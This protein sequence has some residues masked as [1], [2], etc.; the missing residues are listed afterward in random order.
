M[1]AR[2]IGAIAAGNLRRMKLRTTL[3]VAGIV[4]AIA[5]FTSMVSFGTGTQENVERQFNDLGLLSTM[6]VYPRQRSNEPEQEGMPKLDAA[7]LDQFAKIPGVLIVYPYDPFTVGVRCGDSVIETRAQSLALTML[8]TKLFSRIRAGVIF[9]SDTSK[10]AVVSTDFLKK[11]G[12]S[13]PDSA[14]GR[15]L[16][17]SVR[18]STID[19][20]L[21]RVVTDRGRPIWD[22]FRKIRIDSLLHSR[23][24]LLKT[25]RV[26]ANEAVR[27]LV[28]GY[29]NARK[30]ITDTLVICGVIEAERMGRVRV[31][32][33]LL[34]LATGQRFTTSGM[35]SNP[36]DLFAAMSSGTLF[37]GGGDRQEKYFTQATLQLDPR[38]PWAPIKDSIEARGYRTFSFAQE[39]TQIQKAFIYLDM[40]LGAVGLLALLTASLGIVNTMAMSL[41]ERRREIGIFKSLGAD[42]GEI[43]ILFLVESGMV[44]LIGSAAG[45]L[46][47]WI[48]T[49][50]VTVIA[51]VYMRREGIPEVQ[52]FSLPLWLIALALLI[53]TGVAVLAG[54]YPAARAARVD[55]VEA[56][57][58]D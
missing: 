55:P 8:T 52:L 15:R 31:E 48:I 24:Y 49:R 42:E 12:I 32:Q 21:S 13:T 10:E 18:V 41:L 51:H 46:S 3:T 14:L 53:G 37:G 22:R 39:F 45:V 2:D 43:R 57:R 40:A 30:T 47:G 7:A 33:I 25:L 1:T 38:I 6:E 4:I 20:A 36:T 35:S 26:E 29:F 27:R 28:D 23:P 9:P 50:I 5:A 54:S 34:P 58:N 19:S 11:A 17:V 16:I 44:G 56:L